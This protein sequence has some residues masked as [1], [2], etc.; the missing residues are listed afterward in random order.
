MDQNNK[1]IID[2]D[3]TSSKTDTSPQDHQKY[4]QILNEYSQQLK[5]TDK[6]NPVDEHKLP[7]QDLST[8]PSPDFVP[9][10]PPKTPTPPLLQSNSTKFSSPKIGQPQDTPPKASTKKFELFKYLFYITVIIFLVLV[11]L[12]GKDYL[13]LKKLSQDKDSNPSL[14][15]PTTPVKPTET[16]PSPDSQPT[17]LLN[18]VV[19]QIGDS[20]PADDCNSCTCQGTKTGAQ[21]T[22]TLKA[23]QTESSPQDD[24]N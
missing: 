21:V 18:D 5:S 16:S 2:S 19:Y 15:L 24:Q 10:Q 4:Q 12:L 14:P 3:L 13:T 17:C 22:C 8:S 6:T 7:P 11:G 9:S 1:D 20:V 23:C